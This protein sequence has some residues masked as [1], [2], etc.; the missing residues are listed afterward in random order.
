MGRLIDRLL[1]CGVCGSKPNIRDSFDIDANPRYNVSD[2]HDYKL[3]CSN[4]GIHNSTG[5]WF[6]NKYKACLDWNKRQ[7]ENEDGVETGVVFNLG[8]KLKRCPFCGRKMVF[9]REEYINSY[10][11]KVVEQYYMHEDW[12]GIQGKCLLDDMFMPFIIGAGD[13]DP[14]SGHIGEYAAQWNKRV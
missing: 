6:K 10:G 13:A 11:H 5:C 14:E 8:D 1:P 12:N 7:I 9:Y 4:R 2:D 3:F